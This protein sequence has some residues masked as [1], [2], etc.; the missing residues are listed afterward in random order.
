M[1]ALSEMRMDRKFK[2]TLIADSA[3][4]PKI[5]IIIPAYNESACIRNTIAAVQST[6]LKD[7]IVVNDG[8]A[9][10]TSKIAGEC[11]AMVLDL[12]E[13]LGIGGAMQTG[14][15]YA[16]TYGY[17]VAVQFDADGQHNAD[18]IPALVSALMTEDADIVI[19]SRYV[20]QDRRGFKSTFMRRIGIR[21]I[22]ML[23]R[24]LTN[25]RI[26]DPTSGFRAVNRKAISLF[27]QSYPQDYPEPETVVLANNHGLK[28]HEIPVEMF[29]RQG[30]NSTIAFHD[31]YKYMIQ[32]TASIFFEMI[33]KKNR[34]DLCP[35]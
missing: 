10:S 18:Y 35:K 24:G 6:G 2:R 14:Y 33:R 13:N 20:G 28:F 27:A 21:F 25:I 34:I 16:W 31:T 22:S 29:K 1:S 4:S 23:L 17:D 5:I 7:I 3:A 32:V 30:G 9:D 26:L 11:G 8:S 12:P 19:G 15:K